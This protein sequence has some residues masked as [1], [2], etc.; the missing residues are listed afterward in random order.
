MTARCCSSPRMT[1][2]LRI[3]VGYGLEGAL[4]DA[5][6]NRIVD[7][8]IVPYFKR[9]EFYAGIDA[10]VDGDDAGDR[11]RAVAAAESAPA[12]AG[13][14][15]SSRCCS[16]PSGWWWFW[17]A[18]CARCSGRLPGAMLMGGCRV[19]AGLDAGRPLLVALIAGVIAFVFVLLGGGAGGRGFGGGGLGGGFGGGGFGGGSFGGGGF[20][21]GGGGFGGGGASGRW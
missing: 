4:N 10:G 9:G 7:E 16:S 5:T 15:I 18:C 21:G 8:I 20:S 11:R 3:E 17:A 1:A 6:A 19:R 13:D 14:T 12:G 2:T